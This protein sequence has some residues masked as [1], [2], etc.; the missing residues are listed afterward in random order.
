MGLTLVQSH[1]WDLTM[2]MVEDKDLVHLD[3]V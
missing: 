3:S 1:D 2:L